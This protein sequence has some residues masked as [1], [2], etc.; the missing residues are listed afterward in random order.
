MDK[1]DRSGR[2]ARHCL[3][4]TL[5]VITAAEPVALGSILIKAL[6]LRYSARKSV[7]ISLY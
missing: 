1:S 6:Q 4:K 3:L 7:A 5:G 2:G